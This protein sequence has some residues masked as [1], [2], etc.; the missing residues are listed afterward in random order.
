[1]SKWLRMRLCMSANGPAYAHARMQHIRVVHMCS[2]YV[3]DTR[4]LGSSMLRQAC[5][6]MRACVLA[7]LGMRACVLARLGMYAC[8]LTNN[9]LVLFL[10]QNE[11]V[12]CASSHLIYPLQANQ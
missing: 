12:S 6:G 7:R 11:Q 9:A 3:C 8:V 2:I 10:A 4:V 5:V 1:M